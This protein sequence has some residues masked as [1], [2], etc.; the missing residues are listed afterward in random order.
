M[1]PQKKGDV[2]VVLLGPGRVLHPD[3][4][5]QRCRRIN[6]VFSGSDQLLGQQIPAAVLADSIAQ[7]R[8]DREP[9]EPHSSSLCAG[10]SGS[11]AIS[12][13]ERQQ[14]TYVL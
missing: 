11:L 4:G 7:L 6:D 5:C 2:G 3:P 9:L 12:E 13:F 10:R 14:L 8:V 1:N